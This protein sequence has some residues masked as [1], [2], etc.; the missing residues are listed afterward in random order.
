VVVAVAFLAGCSHPS[1]QL[2]PP[3]ETSPQV[4]STSSPVA[5]ETSPAYPTGIRIQSIKLDDSQFMQVGLNPDRSMEVPPLSSPRLVGWFK[6]SHI[7]GDQGVSVIIGHVNGDGMQGSFA[8]LDAVKVGDEVDVDRTD[9][10]VAVF[11]VVDTRLRSK[12]NYA[13][14]AAQV[15]GDTD[16]PVLRMI[17]CGG[18]LGPPP[19]YYESNRIVSADLERIEPKNP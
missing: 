3:N 13:S 4:P 12:A 5:P 14:W 1:A 9:G 2:S 11:K 8:K 18:T 7:P 6:L 15:F 10:T 16:H 17:T 19:T